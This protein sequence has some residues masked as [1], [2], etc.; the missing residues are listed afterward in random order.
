MR[1]HPGQMQ[2]HHAICIEQRTPVDTAA[3]SEREKMV[4]GELY[5]AMGPELAAARQAA[6]DLTREYNNSS[7]LTPDQ[8]SAQRSILKRLVGSLSDEQ[9]PCVEPPFQCDYVSVS[10]LPPPPGAIFTRRIVSDEDCELLSLIPSKASAGRLSTLRG[11]LIAGLQHPPR[12]AYAGPQAHAAL[13]R[14]P[15]QRPTGCLPQAATCM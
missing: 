11:R 6:R 2:A 8:L 7:A 3:M 14:Q 5:Y 1:E 15:T 10:R 9:P 4:A 12:C 13:M